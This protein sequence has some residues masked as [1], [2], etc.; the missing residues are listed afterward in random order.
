MGLLFLVTSLVVNI[1]GIPSHARIFARPND[2]YFPNGAVFAHP[3]YRVWFPFILYAITVLAPLFL[4]VFQTKARIRQSTALSIVSGFSI[5]L[6]IVALVDQPWLLMEMW[7]WQII[8]PRFI[9][10]PYLLPIASIG[11]ACF[12]L[13]EFHKRWSD[14]RHA[15]QGRNSLGG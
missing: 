12:L 7:S 13:I 10:L 15:I 5:A 4:G 14:A 3:L 6:V 11:P 9:H 2:P 8:P 1:I